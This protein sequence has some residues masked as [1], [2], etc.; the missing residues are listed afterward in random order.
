MRIN[1]DNLDNR[2]TTE[3]NEFLIGTPK[4]DVLEK[5][6]SSQTLAIY[7]NETEK[8]ELRKLITNFD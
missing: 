6:I 5:I 3:S 2:K 7:K 4:S 1:T 8:N